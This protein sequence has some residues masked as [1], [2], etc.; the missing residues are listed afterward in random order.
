MG[1]TIALVAIIGGGAYFAYWAI[2]RTL[3][4][5]DKKP[6][7]SHPKSNKKSPPRS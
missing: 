4:E 3:N 7:Q 1:T 2:Q 5:T 6:N